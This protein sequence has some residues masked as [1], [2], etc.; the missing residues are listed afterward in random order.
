MK[1]IHKK[2][3]NLMNFIFCVFK[4]LQCSSNICLFLSEPSLTYKLQFFCTEYQYVM[5]HV[6]RKPAVCNSKNKNVDQLRGYRTADRRLYFHY[7]DTNVYFQL[8]YYDIS[9]I[10]F[11]CR[12]TFFFFLNVLQK[13]SKIG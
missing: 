10:S 2:L 8:S 7:I 13:M 1:L 3:V 5:S 4:V 6:T 9:R 11:D 12:Q